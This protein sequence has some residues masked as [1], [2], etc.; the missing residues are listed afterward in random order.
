MGASKQLCKITPQGTSIAM[1]ILS[2]LLVQTFLISNIAQ[3]DFSRDVPDK[4]PVSHFS[5]RKFRNPKID[6]AVISSQIS[7]ARRSSEEK[8]LVRQRRGIIGTGVKVASK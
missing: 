3:A 5:N 6:D 4:M 7:T 8:V 2:F 1:K